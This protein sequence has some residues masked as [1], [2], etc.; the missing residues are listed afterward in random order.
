MSAY[1]SKKSNKGKALALVLALAALAVLA[2]GGLALYQRQAESDYQAP[3]PADHTVQSQI[4]VLGQD[5]QPFTADLTLDQVPDA[6]TQEPDHAGTLETVTYTTNTYG[7][8][9]AQE[10][11]IQKQAMVYLPYGYDPDQHYNIMYLMHGAGGTIGRFFG[12]PDE[13]RTF[14]Y[15][16]DNMIDRGEIVPMIFVNLTY[17]PEN[18]MDRQPDFD[19]QYTKYYVNEL[20]NDVLPQIESHYSTYAASTDLEG[21]QASRWHRAFGGFSMGGVTTMY[22]MTDCLDIFHSFM[23][24]SGSLYWSPE[25]RESQGVPN[26]AAGIVAQG[27]ADQGYGPDDF[28]LYTCTG[29][30]DFARDTMERQLS[31]MQAYPDVFKFGQDGSPANTAYEL[32]EGERHSGGHGGDRYLYNALSIFSAIMAG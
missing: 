19:A 30:D 6:Y 10:K 16:I 4:Q 9:G 20:R 3:A 29:G 11:E 22:R 28:F 13:P 5:G 15:V 14:K 27:L 18:G 24:M 2:V 31:D 17:Y 7:I 8:Y 21:L 26:Y 32:Y 1:P 12:W 23:A 25:A